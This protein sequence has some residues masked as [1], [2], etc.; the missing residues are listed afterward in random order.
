MFAFVAPP[1]LRG[2]H[3]VAEAAGEV[4]VGS[5]SPFESMPEADWAETEEGTADLP[6]LVDGVSDRR[7]PASIISAVALA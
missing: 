4:A 7:K 3:A 5:A 2:I 1:L 6:S